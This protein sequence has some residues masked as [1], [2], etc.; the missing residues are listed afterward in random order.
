MILTFTANNRPRE[1]GIT[2]DSWSFVR[3]IGDIRIQVCVEP[4]D[5]TVINMCEANYMF[6]D[7][8]LNGEQKGA[9]GNP[10][11]ALE[12][13]FATGEDF[14]VLGEDDVVVSTDILEF[15][16]H[17]SRTYADDPTIM[18]VCAWSRAAS[19][20]FAYLYRGQFASTIWGTWRDKWEKLM[21]QQWTEESPGWDFNMQELLK[22]YSM[23]CIRPEVSRSQHIG[24]NGT[25]SSELSY[26]DSV[27]QSFRREIEPIKEY[28]EVS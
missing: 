21:H 9:W 22:V 25:F 2:L 16:D 17:C 18:A 23:Q 12:Q 20:R 7:V 11:Y 13:A 6:E 19:N 3:G 5:D 4:N 8:Y 14:V 24:K 27:S 28:R 10:K 26:P 1:W 15:F